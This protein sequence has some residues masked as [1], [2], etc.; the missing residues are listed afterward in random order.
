MKGVSF[1]S[2]P[3]SPQA[4][5]F[6]SYFFPFGKNLPTNLALFPAYV[7]MCGLSCHAQKKGKMIYAT[8]QT[9]RCEN[10]GKKKSSQA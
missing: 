7:G 5:S 10:E 4:P 1:Q 8:F 9:R 2:S 3:Q 6:F